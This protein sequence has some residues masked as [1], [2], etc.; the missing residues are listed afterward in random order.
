[1][2]G[3]MGSGPQGRSCGVRG[4]GRWSNKR[5]KFI[6]FVSCLFKNFPCDWRGSEPPGTK[7]RLVRTLYG[8]K[9]CKKTNSQAD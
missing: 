4:R 1:M 3:H 9:C 6:E 2:P 5:E 7:I 8:L